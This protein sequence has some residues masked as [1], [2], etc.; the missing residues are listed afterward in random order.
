MLRAEA[1]ATNS[2]GSLRMTELFVFLES[3]GMFRS[4]S[5]AEARNV[6]DVFPRP[7]GRGFYR[8]AAAQHWDARARLTFADQTCRY[9]AVDFLAVTPTD[10]D[11]RNSVAARTASSLASGPSITSLTGNSVRGCA[12]D[13]DE[14]AS[15]CNGNAMYGISEALV[16][17][18]Q[19][20]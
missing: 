15:T 10:F 19:T 8:R 12:P 2:E 16:E 6:W 11:L 5:G 1:R 3:C 18:K 17:R 20:G 4:R 7:E 13:P 14:A 9:G